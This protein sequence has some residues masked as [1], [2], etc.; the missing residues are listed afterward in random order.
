MNENLRE[1]K[2]ISEAPFF[3]WATLGYALFYVF[4]LYKNVAGITFPLFTA[5]TLFY[6]VLCMRKLDVKVKK[7]SIFYMICIELLG[8][9]TCLTGSW[10][11]I[12]LNKFVI[13]F[14]II[15]FLLH[16]FY[17]NKHWN[18][19]E[20][21]KAYFLATTVPVIYIAKPFLHLCNYRKNRAV[22][23]EEKKKSKI[24]YVILGVVL[25]IPL[26]IVVLLLLVSADAVF[27]NIFEKMFEDFNLLS[28][29]GDSILSGILFVVVFFCA[30]M[31]ISFLSD[32]KVNESKQAKEGG[33]PLIAI[34]VCSILSFIYV[35]FCGIQVVY[36]FIGSSGKFVL[37]NDMTYAQYA[38]EGFFQLLF[39][40]IIN[41]VLVLVG[42]Y[43]F[44]ENKVLKAL[45]CIITSCTY[46]MIASSAMRMLLYIQYKYLTFL[47]IFV[48]WALL[49]IALVMIGT[50]ISIFKK[51]FNFFKYST[52]VVTCLYLVLSF[53]R[54]D[55]WIAKVNIDN[56]Q[57]ETQYEFFR[58]TEL[59]DD[60]D[61]LFVN[62]SYDAAPVTLNYSD[63]SD[64]SYKGSYVHKRNRYIQRILDV[65][66]MGIRDFN[67]SK[68]V[69]KYIAKHTPYYV[70]IVN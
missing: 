46:I 50:M 62:L 29:M 9:S 69:A 42:I 53:A 13:F 4:C 61:Y 64:P 43:L 16:N 49:V 31:L 26:V 60:Y 8:L 3:L 52:I 25:S 2:M 36:L 30:Y 10:I 6:F 17:E 14:L 44:R 21:I 51:D 68:A 28:L 66:D 70:N 12:L 47:R 27:G 18:F 33:E 20:H 65:E 63:Y 55:Y 22:S 40:C 56:M 57:A 24:V 7:Y 23:G 48:L 1:K 38:R 45:L 19:L 35:I 67:I 39:V 59:Y 15:V 54:V 58:G 37:P 5:G 41:L 32:F 34:T 11:I